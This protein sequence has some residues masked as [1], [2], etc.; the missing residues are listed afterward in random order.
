MSFHSASPFLLLHQC[1]KTAH[2]KHLGVLVSISASCWSPSTSCTI[3]GVSINQLRGFAVISR[4]KQKK[5]KVARSIFRKS[6]QTEAT[7]KDVLVLNRREDLTISFFFFKCT[8]SVLHR[9]WFE[10]DERRLRNP[11][12]H[13]QPGGKTPHVEGGGVS[14]PEQVSDERRCFVRANG[15]VFYSVWDGR[16]F[17]LGQSERIMKTSTAH[18][19]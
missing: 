17:F 2:L 11:N 14:S 3:P 4:Q 9:S 18:M 15:L 6:R 19:F 8:V 7:L 5:K 12:S 10:F 16:G 13:Q 1:S